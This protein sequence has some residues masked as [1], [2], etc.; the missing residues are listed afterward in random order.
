MNRAVLALIFIAN[1]KENRAVPAMVDL[2]QRIPY[3]QE[4]VRK[5]LL[6]LDTPE[7]KEAL[8]SLGEKQENE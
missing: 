1:Q 2:A 6:Q 4:R 5:T 8:G 7:A 3:F